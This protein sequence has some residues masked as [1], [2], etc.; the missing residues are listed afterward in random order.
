MSSKNI[1]LNVFAVY[2]QTIKAVIE[3]EWLREQCTMKTLELMRDDLMIQVDNIIHNILINT[4][5]NFPQAPASGGTPRMRE[6]IN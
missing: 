3:N 2:R 4:A 6:A 1:M 5:D